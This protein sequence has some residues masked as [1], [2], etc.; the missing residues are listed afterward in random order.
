[1]SERPTLLVMAKT[2]RFG[3]GKTRLARGLGAGAA[4]RIN[5]AMQ[6]AT[7]RL[8]RDPRWRTILLVA[9]DRDLRTRL[10]GVWP[11]DLARRAQ[12]RGD[13]GARLARAFRALGRRPAAVIGVD[14]PDQDRR[15]IWAAMRLGLRAGAALG[16]TTDG[17]FWILAVRCASAAAP[18][19]G[20]VRWSSPHACDDMEAALRG[21]VRTRILADIDEADDWRAYAQRRAMRSAESSAR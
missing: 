4:L 16:P 9:P 6:A 14:C 19:F 11:D 21:A 5:R 3:H 7:L 18:A 8:C 13:L 1:M 17:G 12:G 2:P 20:Q 10:P 15:A